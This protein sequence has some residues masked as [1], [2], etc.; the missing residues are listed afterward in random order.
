MPWCPPLKA[1]HRCRCSPWRFQMVSRCTGLGSVFFFFFFLQIWFDSIFFHNIF[2]HLFSFYFH[3]SFMCFL[4]L[5]WHLVNMDAGPPSRWSAH[6]SLRPGCA[7]RTAAATASTAIA[8]WGWMAL[9]HS[10]TNQTLF[11]MII[12][13]KRS[14]SLLSLL[15]WL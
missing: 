9:L 11:I 3:F 8:G 4:T 13:M 1:C 2:L 12:I 10:G 6:H 5:R 7:V 15:L 14:W